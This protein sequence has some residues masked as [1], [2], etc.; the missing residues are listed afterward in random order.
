[1]KM[2]MK[3]KMRMN[4]TIV[5]VL[6]NIV[7]F[8]QIPAGYYNNAEGKKQ[9]E[10]KSALCA[11]I[12]PHRVY[13]YGGASTWSCFLKSDVDGN[14][15]CWDIYS[16]NRNSF[17]A[18]NSS[19]TGMNIEHSVPN[20]WWG[21]V[22]NDAYK[23]IQ[24]LNP[25]DAIANG[26][27]SNYPMGY[28]TTVTHDN[29]VVKQ[30]TGIPDGLTTV[31]NLWEPAD[32]YKGD[33]ARQY[34]YMVT[35][36]EE[37]APMWM[38]LGLTVFSNTTYPT[39]LDGFRNLMLKWN[40]QDPV[41]KKEIDRNNAIY[42]LQQNRNPYIDYPN[43]AE[44]VWGNMTT[45]PFT[46]TGIVDF[47]YLST[48]SNG[49]V[50]DFGKLVYQQSASYTID[51]K[52]MNLTGDLT[53][54][55]SGPNA[56]NFSLPEMIITKAEAEAG[57]KMEIKYTA[58]NIGAQ[59]AQISISGG[60]TSANYINLK[61]NSTDNFKA[62]PAD[63]VNF[64]GFDANWTFS[65]NATGYTLNVYSMKS[66]GGIQKRTLLE[67]DFLTGLPSGWTTGGYVDNSVASNMKMASA[68]NV[69]KLILPALN[70]S[71]SNS[72]L[73]LRARQ[74]N[75]DAGSPLTA[76]I[77]DQPLA[78]WTTSASNQDFTVNVP[79]G[80]SSS[81]ITLAVA[82]GKRV[83]I[84]YVKVETKGSDLSKV[85]VIGYPKSIGNI[86][87]YPVTGLEPDSTYYFTVLPEGNN[88][89]ASNTIQQRT[90]LST[91]VKQ[92]QN[93]ILRWN[94]SSE[95]IRVWNLYSDCN[96]NVF[97]I[98]GKKIQTLKPTTS[99]VLLQLPQRGIYLL[100]IQQN[101]TINT[102]KIIY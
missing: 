70:L 26:W 81:I 56:S 44:F 29:G 98:L 100:Q 74:Y 92:N 36:Y 6:L 34:M 1:M 11:I 14:G 5:L 49:V 59:T 33:F 27:K 93:K 35:C 20:S 18:D 8:A 91:E 43:L 12:R 15:K 97:N 63:N 62:I 71:A 47:P 46:T 21:K 83:Y 28:V 39:F 48:P 50:V 86:L 84:D 88:A 102:Y 89:I 38:S 9:A 68:A 80:S 42:S 10:L 95:G 73:T 101:A 51:L 16:N 55:L 17:N 66:D 75:S 79:Q 23:D 61:A 19:I 52:A 25:S 72:I 37:M 94:V 32:Q 2:K 31:T 82:A 30:G 67:N 7:L 85:P 65:A 58:L 69:G 77:D 24:L 3:F 13:S 40:N 87:T 90:D 22:E 96:L 60:G 99:E 57:Y 78:I 45:V 64:S 54:T 76:T 41:D 53:V 4:V